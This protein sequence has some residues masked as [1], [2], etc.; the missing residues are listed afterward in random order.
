LTG[1]M[2]ME[3]HRPL[4]SKVV[5]IMGGSGGIGAATAR[6][7]AE[8]GAKVAVVA[9]RERQ[10]AV[11]VAGELPGEGHRA[12]VAA[13][14][15]SAA[16]ASLADVVAADFGRVDVLVNSAGFTR[17]I[18]HADLDT[19]TDELFDHIL[20]V[21]CRGMFA[22]VR[23]FA[24]HLRA[25]GEG[26]VVNI[27][28]IAATTGVGSNIAYCVAK[29]GT[30]VMGSALAR[31]LAPEIRVMTVSPGI[32]ATGF[33]PGRDLAWQEKQAAATP[34]KRV[35]SPEDVGKAVLACAVGLTFSTGSVVQVDGGRHL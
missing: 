9:G 18:P 26:L 2:A 15:D 3:T 5:V 28:S 16:L 31:A 22:A 13:I 19:L 23:A 33:V 24:K 17:A 7:F 35:A 6:L 8:A 11:A 25:H 32:V 21:N 20:R 12:Y 14:E 27:S 10:K 30:D 34:L 4:A 1:G 29:A